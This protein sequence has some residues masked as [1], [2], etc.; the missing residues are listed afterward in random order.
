MKKASCIV[1]LDYPVLWKKSCH[2]DNGIGYVDH[3]L[4]PHG[5]YG[6]AQCDGYC[7]LWWWF[8]VSVYD[9][10]YPLICDIDFNIHQ[11]TKRE[12][13]QQTRWHPQIFVCKLPASWSGKMPL[14]KYAN[15]CIVLFLRQLGCHELGFSMCSDRFW[16][17]N[18]LNRTFISGGCAIQVCY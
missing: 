9:L 5:M 4:K 13:N 1:L 7:F 17:R 11:V 10:A 12:E 16:E 18:K 2:L 6:K 8:G 3:E 15:H 14:H